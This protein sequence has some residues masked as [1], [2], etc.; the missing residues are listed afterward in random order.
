MSHTPT[1]HLI[2]STDVEDSMHTLLFGLNA[3]IKRFRH[4][5]VD[6]EYFSGLLLRLEQMV[7]GGLQI[8]Q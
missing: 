4:W 1:S 7:V 8:I 6:P 3:L 2:S 5:Y